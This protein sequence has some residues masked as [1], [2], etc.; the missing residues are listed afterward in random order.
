MARFSSSLVR[1]E[2][3]LCDGIT[4]AKS[5][6]N[7]LAQIL[8][9]RA[10]LLNNTDARPYL[11]LSSTT[12]DADLKREYLEKAIAREPSN[13][14][15]R[16]SLA[17]LT[18]KLDPTKI[19]C[20]TQAPPHRLS[21]ASLEVKA[22][23]F[24]CPQCGGRMSFSLL[25]ESLTCEY[26]GY[27][28][29][30]LGPDEER[31]SSY[32]AVEPAE[33]IL[34]FV[35]PTH[36]GHRWAETQHGVDCENCGAV[37]LLPAGQKARQCPYCGSNQFVEGMEQGELIDPQWI[38]M[39][40]I[41]E[42]QAISNARKWLRRGFFAPDNLAHACKHL[43]LRPAYYSFWIFDGSLEVAW[44]C[45]VL[46]GQGD[47][48]RWIARNGVEARF[49]DDILVSGLK[50]LSPAHLEWIQPFKL[51][52]LQPFS[53]DYLAGWPAMI[54][55]RSLAEASLVA[56]EK[57]LK[58][59]RPELSASIAIG[60]EKRDLEMSNANWSGITYQHVLLPLWIGS[61][62]FQ[63]K[64]YPL[65]VNGQTGKVGGNKPVDRIKLVIT[66]LSVTI[67]LLMLLV[68]L[69]NLFF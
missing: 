51:D 33:Q 38:G 37:V 7:R 20:E 58:E 47:A 60:Y 40:K 26:C 59:I 57:V 25:V 19:I 35:L 54:Y 23:T 21:E 9:N 68:F 46:E 63:G 32:S 31:R 12:S 66:I 61:Y 8:L 36:Q 48:K 3:C 6:D 10:I 62:Q 42:E 53:R 41:D 39:L 34:D 13:M 5:G 28:R 44:S 11:W 17:I 69:R 50:A 49:F 2:D 30:D 22:T 52:D 29:G 4:A 56:R 15:A 43:R 27:Q 1:Y 45:E 55:N 64:T 67:L 65:L 16:R 24:Q 14:A 18:G